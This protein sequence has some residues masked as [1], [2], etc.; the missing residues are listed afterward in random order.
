MQSLGPKQYVVNAVLVWFRGTC[1]GGCRVLQ[2]GQQVKHVPCS[3]AQSLASASIKSFRKK[4]NR[5]HFLLFSHGHEPTVV[6][7]SL[8]VSVRLTA[9][10]RG[11]CLSAMFLMISRGRRK[12]G[13]ERL[14]SADISFCD[15]VYSGRLGVLRLR[16]VVVLDGTGVLTMSWRFDRDLV[17]LP[18]RSTA[19]V[20]RGVLRV[21]V[22]TAFGMLDYTLMGCRI[23]AQGYAVP[24]LL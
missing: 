22:R 18:G 11:R 5:C 16:R 24:P 15:L 1:N 12:R 20:R 8:Q 6:R 7:A 23:C 2:V 3:L 19:S 9:E 21:L 13:S 4:L 17:A 14:G 10:S